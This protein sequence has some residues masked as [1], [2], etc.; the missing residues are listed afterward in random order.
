MLVFVPGREGPWLDHVVGATREHRAGELHFVV[1]TDGVVRARGEGIVRRVALRKP[2]EESSDAFEKPVHQSELNAVLRKLGRH[3]HVTL[4]DRRSG[5][6]FA[7]E[8]VRREEA[9]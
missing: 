4:V 3:A 1:C 5:Q 7:G 6:V 8:L 2:T 9:A